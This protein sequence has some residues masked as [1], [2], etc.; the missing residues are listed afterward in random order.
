MALSV[1]IRRVARVC[2][3]RFA[4]LQCPKRLLPY[5]VATEKSVEQ[6]SVLEFRQLNTDTD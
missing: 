3:G 4:R 2:A 6:L 1:Q 5:S